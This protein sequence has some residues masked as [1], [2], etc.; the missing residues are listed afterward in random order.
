MKTKE[1]ITFGRYPKDEDGRKWPIEWIVL[2]EYGKNFLLIS[3]YGIDSKS[4]EKDQKKI[5]WEKCSLRIWLNCFFINCAFTEDEQKRIVPIRVENLSN[6]QYGTLGG[7]ET[8]DRVFLLSV[9]EA[10][11]YFLCDSERQTKATTYA[12]RRGAQS[13][14]NGFCWWWLRSPG[15]TSFGAADVSY[16][17]GIYDF[18]D[19]VHSS[20]A[21]IRPALILKKIR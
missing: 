19:V 9:D 14:A 1:V 7:A 8:Y 21:A 16:D 3:K 17:G 5:T 6:S 4:Y 13:D 15:Y 12:S 10:D 18:G 20:G 11:S 2:N